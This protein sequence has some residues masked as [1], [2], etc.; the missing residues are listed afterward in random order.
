MHKDA[1]GLINQL[2]LIRESIWKRVVLLPKGKQTILCNTTKKQ[3][4]KILIRETPYNQQYSK[5]KNGGGTCRI[6]EA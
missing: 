3:S 1:D 5:G 6:R 4:V 2:S